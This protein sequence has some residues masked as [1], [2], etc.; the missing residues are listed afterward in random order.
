MPVSNKKHAELQEELREA[1]EMISNLIA[2]RDDSV[3]A[4][5]RKLAALHE[6]MPVFESKTELD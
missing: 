5:N 3:M 4:W 1:Y 2:E 6:R